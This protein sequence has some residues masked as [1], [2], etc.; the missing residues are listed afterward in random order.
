MLWA[1]LAISMFFWL[2][3][4]WEWRLPRWLQTRI[5]EFQERV[6]APVCT[7]HSAWPEAESAEEALR[8]ME[9]ELLQAERALEMPLFLVVELA[10]GFEQAYIERS[11]LLD[12]R[13]PASV[14][15]DAKLRNE[16]L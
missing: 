4:A 2:T 10:H 7:F 11:R 3:A 8:R 16:R 1:I 5:L 12:R 15:R 9:K 6:S 13:F 14:I